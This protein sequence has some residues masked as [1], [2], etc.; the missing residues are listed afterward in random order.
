MLKRFHRQAKKLKT[1]E[2][3]R[4]IQKFMKKK[5]KEL[6]DKKN[7]I[8]EGF[9]KF[10]LFIKR[11]GFDKIKNK[12]NNKLNQHLLTG[13]VEKKDETHKN[14][15]KNKLNQWKDNAN[16]IKKINSII[17]IQSSMR[18]SL[19]K[20]NL[21]NLKKKKLLL[22][23]IHDN[24]ENKNNIKLAILLRDWLHRALII[25]N[26]TSAKKI[27][28]KYRKFKN[29]QKE[30]QS[31]DLLRN[32]FVKKFKNIISKIL[33]KLSRVTGNKGEILSKT[34]S[35]IIIQKPFNKL[36]NNLK[37]LGKINGLKKIY[38]K[39][40][41]KIKQY[42]LSKSIKKWKENSCDETLKY[43]LIL[44]NFLREKYN[45]KLQEEK[46]RREA[47]LK[48]LL[49]RKIKNNLYKLSLPFKIWNKKTKLDKINENVIKIQN[50][51][52]KNI[53]KKKAN[54]LKIANK[55]MDLVNNIK[56]KR[57]VDIIKKVK[58]T[59]ELDNKKKTLL[60]KIIKKKSVS[61]KKSNIDKY[62]NR[63]KKI[64]QLS[65]NNANKIQNVFRAYLAKKKR[66]KLF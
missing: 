9:E 53:A 51:Y 33:E 19:A 13:I 12:S 16:L 41:D 1:D 10:S 22:K 38:P 65:K 55:F 66:D 50:N 36:I 64:C 28:D 42:F 14:I 21:E 49:D 61:D 46:E 18:K 3:I 30:N 57:L 24:R 54:N 6:L 23:T 63:W 4:K 29:K 52:R 48:N 35:D 27:Q 25:R 26:N 58:D 31:K 7:M 60:D 39:V 17:K 62:F 5:L 44:Q 43:T 45:E 40:Y 8:K 37:F 20:D 56:T 59:K 11:R 15:L 32:L 47:L 2:S 34:L